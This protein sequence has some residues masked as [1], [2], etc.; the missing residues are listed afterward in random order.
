[1]SLLPASLERL[2]V[3]LS[4]LPGIGER[5]ATR[6]AFAALA[7]GDEYLGD[8][9]RALDEASEKITYCQSCHMLA[10][11]ELCRVCAD[12]GRDARLMCCLLYT[13]PS[14]RDQ[15]GSRMPSSA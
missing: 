14:P 15:R 1:M 5:T 9:A 6:L 11:S 7:E 8:L 12:P 2:I 3:L 4:R 10:E 13:S